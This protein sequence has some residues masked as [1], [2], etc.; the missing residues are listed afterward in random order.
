M[1]LQPTVLLSLRSGKTVAL[2]SVQKPKPEDEKVTRGFV[3]PEG[4]PG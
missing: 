3:V 1:L 2:F 4:F